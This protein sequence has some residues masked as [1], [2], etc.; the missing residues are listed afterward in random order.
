MGQVIKDDDKM[1]VKD[2]DLVIV[3]ADWSHMGRS[4]RL[5]LCYILHT[6]GDV[7]ALRVFRRGRQ[8]LITI[9][10]PKT[11]FHHLKKLT[12]N[13]Y[14]SSFRFTCTVQNGFGVDMISTFLYPL[15]P[16]FADMA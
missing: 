6:L 11:K 14:S 12:C 5:H 10:T 8:G 7:R 9:K 16:S 3:G 15:A 1:M 13:I 2:T 4:V